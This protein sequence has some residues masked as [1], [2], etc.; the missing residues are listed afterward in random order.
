MLDAKALDNLCVNE[1]ENE[2]IVRVIEACNH[3][4]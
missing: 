4:G 1:I 2:D 3:L